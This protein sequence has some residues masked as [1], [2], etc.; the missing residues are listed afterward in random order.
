MRDEIAELLKSINLLWENFNNCRAHFPYIPK[1]AKG[2][3]VAK[4]APYYIKQGFDVSFEFLKGLSET[5]IEKINE[6]GHWINQNAIIRLC[7]VLESYHIISNSIKINFNLVG[8]EHVNIVRRLRNCFAHSSGQYKP[9]DNEHKKTLD[10]MKKYLRIETNN[11]KKWPL[12]IDTVMQPLF[13]GCVK[14][15]KAMKKSA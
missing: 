10:L 1:E 4:T 5:D 11:N 7:V 14:Y 9:Y 3:N 12:S 15:V 8:A 13:E 2:V 6:I